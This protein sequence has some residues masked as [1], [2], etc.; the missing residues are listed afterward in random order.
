MGN[1]EINLT[2]PLTCYRR[3]GL[4]CPTYLLV[5]QRAGDYFACS[6]GH[7]QRP[8]SIVAKTN[9]WISAYYRPNLH[10]AEASIDELSLPVFSSGSL[11]PSDSPD[12]FL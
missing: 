12:P 11:K 5:Y 2:Q 1:A 10:D 9:G 7:R 3:V 8:T 6:A 4:V